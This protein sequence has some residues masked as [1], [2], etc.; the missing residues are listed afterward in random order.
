MV[1]ESANTGDEQSNWAFIS[2]TKMGSIGYASPQR[3]GLQQVMKYTWQFQQ[4]QQE[5][6]IQK[7]HILYSVIR[8][9]IIFHGCSKVA[10][11]LS[12]SENGPWG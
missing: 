2:P 8:Y 6:F 10:G 1:A 9:C 3:D 4:I 5:I 12:P 7:C 11:S